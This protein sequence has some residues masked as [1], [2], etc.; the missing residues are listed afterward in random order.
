MITFII[1]LARDMT[2]INSTTW[3]CGEKDDTTPSLEKAIGLYNKLSR[4]GDKV[5]I[6][7]TAKESPHEGNTIM[8]GR[9][10]EYL[11]GKK[12]PDH[13][14]LVKKARSWNTYG[15]MEA[16][17]EA[18]ADYCKKNRLE[19][20]RIIISTRWFHTIRAWLIGLYVRGSQKIT[21]TQTIAP[22]CSLIKWYELPMA[23]LH[24]A[25]GILVIPFYR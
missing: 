14:I 22:T 20:S 15:E 5:F 7:V 17:Y 6:T 4:E 2:R 9:M 10:R 21:P 25:L 8:C 23:L 18:I 1:T 16:A 3:I 11:I 13:A 24:E 12:I 19:A